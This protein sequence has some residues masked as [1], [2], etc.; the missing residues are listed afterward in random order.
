MGQSS[1]SSNG[2]A[3]ASSSRARVQGVFCSSPARDRL[4]ENPMKTKELQSVQK[5][6]RDDFKE[7]KTSVDVR[8]HEPKKL[9]LKATSSGNQHATENLIL[10][11]RDANFESS[12]S[13]SGQKGVAFREENHECCVSPWDMES[14]S[15]GGAVTPGRVSEEN[16][17]QCLNAPDFLVDFSCSSPLAKHKIT[18]STSQPSVSGRLGG[19]TE[20][21]ASNPFP[22]I[23]PKLIV[24]HDDLGPVQDSPHISDFTFSMGGY[25]LDLH[26]DE[27]SP[28][29]DSGCG[30]S[31]APFLFHRKLSSSSSAG[32]SSASSFEESEDDFTG[33]DIEPSLSPS[34][35][36]CPDELKGAKSWRKLKTMVHCSP[37]VVSFKKRYPWVQ[38]AGHAGNF[39]AG[40]NGKLLKKYCECEQQ[41]L[42][43]L[44]NDILRPFVPG[45]Y[46]IVQ[47]NDQDYNLMDDLLTDFD[48]PSIMDCKM[49]S[50]TYLEE[51]LVKARERPRLRKDMYEK[52]VAVDPGAPSPEERAQQAVLKPR[53]MQWRETLSSTATLGFRI[54]GIRKADGTCNTSFKKTKQKEQ[55]MKAL[56]DFVDGNTQLLR[57]YLQRL[58]ELRSALETSELFRTHEVVGSSL[59]FVHDASGLAR[60][61]MID[62]GK[63][64]PLPP[65]QTLDHRTPWAEGN[66]ED[67]YLWGLDN[68]IEIF[69][70]MLQDATPPP[71]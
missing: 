26:P 24:T 31:P 48:S 4:D 35:I 7:G 60:V 18:K 36:G 64:V 55:V 22:R 16:V 2:A 25:S 32:L 19:E 9:L 66:R 44:M 8:V 15:E 5:C 52:M 70:G 40:E 10:L 34:M 53:Y 68:L 56:R 62:F 67:G 57:S 65:P 13:Q 20:Q 6:W 38:L 41:C 33:S 43:K 17:T 1:S 42:E 71:P 59:L 12:D 27:D 63:T 69:G 11:S 61:W 51:E 28:C 29:S 3:L 37:F 50:R 49:G 21:Q 23:I 54:E 47:Q 14:V 58:E 39:Q 46:G 45:Y 30:G